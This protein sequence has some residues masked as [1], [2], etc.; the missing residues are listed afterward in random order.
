MK[1]LNNFKNIKSRWAKT[2]ES[3]YV[4]GKFR[5]SS[6]LSPLHKY[7]EEKANGRDEIDMGEIMRNMP[8]KVL[9]EK[10]YNS[11]VMIKHGIMN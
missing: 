5:D 4:K 1:I 10:K 11:Q 8:K 9:L 6:A 2:C 7:F 3:L